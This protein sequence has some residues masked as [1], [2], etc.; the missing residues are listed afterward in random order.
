MN[1]STTFLLTLCLE[2]SFEF[3]GHPILEGGDVL[4]TTQEILDQVIRRH[5]AAGFEDYAAVAHGGVA[6]EKI[7][8]IEL[9]EEIFGIERA[10]V[11][12]LNTGDTGE[13][14]VNLAPSH[15]APFL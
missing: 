15:L 12:T 7:L 14:G 8:M 9:Q 6:R 11:K 1:Y 3:F 5:G 2:R 13:H 10:K 4:G